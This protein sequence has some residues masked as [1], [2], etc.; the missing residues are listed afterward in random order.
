MY[1]HT[2]KELGLLQKLEHLEY[3]HLLKILLPQKLRL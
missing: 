1:Q 3:T 2:R